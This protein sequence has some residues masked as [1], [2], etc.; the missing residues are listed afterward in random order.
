MTEPTL[1][2]EADRAIADARRGKPAL[3]VLRE[4]M[5]L[6]VGLAAFYQPKPVGSTNENFDEGRFRYYSER[7]A[8]LAKAIASY[9]APRL[10]AVAVAAPPPE[11]RTTR[12]RLNIFGRVLRLPPVIEGEPPSVVAPES[13]VQQ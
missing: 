7:A 12:F 10:Q 13:D 2:S 4:L 5:S 6:A 9:E 1:R 3:E 11:H 8:D